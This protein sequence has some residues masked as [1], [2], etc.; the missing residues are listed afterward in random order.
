MDNNSFQKA[1][2]V[3][4]HDRLLARTILKLFSH[5]IHPNHIT[6][7]RF[8]ATPFVILLLFFG[9]YKTGFIAF[10]LTAFTDMLD[11][12]MAR[13]RDQVTEWG[14]IYDPLAD[15]IL[16]AGMVF[17][18]VIKSINFWTSVMIIALEVIIV[19]AAWKR[20]TEGRIIQA[21]LWGK[22]KM[23]LQVLGVSVLILAAMFAWPVLLPYASGMLY[24]AIL[25]AVISLLTHGV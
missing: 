1:E 5:K 21:N 14:K 19:I 12:S 23:L 10:L 4:F 6:M 11:G 3:Y 8:A 20:K 15:K 25:F 7:F 22:I 2:I 13:T 16:I 17:V 9:F 18:I 24:L